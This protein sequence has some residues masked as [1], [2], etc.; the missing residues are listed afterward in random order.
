M[1]GDNIIKHVKG[2]LMQLNVNVSTGTAKSTQSRCEVEDSSVA[3]TPLEDSSVAVTPFR[4]KQ[5]IHP[6]EGNARRKV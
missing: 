1:S 4:Q 2:E 3:V 6:F 5:R